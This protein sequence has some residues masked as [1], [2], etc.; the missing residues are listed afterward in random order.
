KKIFVEIDVTR[1]PGTKQKFAVKRAGV[2]N[3]LRKGLV[4]HVVS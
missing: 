2:S 1:G 4:G 3:T